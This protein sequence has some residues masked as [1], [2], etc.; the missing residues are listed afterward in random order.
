MTASYVSLFILLILLATLLI[1]P[2]SAAIW[3]EQYM[4]RLKHAELVNRREVMQDLLLENCPEDVS[5]LFS[6][7]DPFYPITL[8]TDSLRNENTLKDELPFYVVEEDEIHFPAFPWAANWYLDLKKDK[9]V[10]GVEILEANPERTVFKYR[11]E[12]LK[13]REAAG[14]RFKVTH[15]HHCGACSSLKD[16]Y[17]YKAFP[18]LT[19]PA[20]S[21]AYMFPIELQLECMLK[22]GFSEPCAEAWAYNA[23]ST[24][25]RCSSICIKN[26]F[27]DSV[28]EKRSLEE[29]T[30]NEDLE[31]AEKSTLDDCLLCDEYV[32]GPGFKYSA[33]R[34]RRSSGLNSSIERRPGEV[35]AH[36]NHNYFNDSI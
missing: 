28:A 25:N 20:K 3:D 13:N 22:I 4:E 11:L 21:C 36:T 23:R 18:D 27:K 30:A 34:T 35:Y 32:S 15:A 17:I 19:R 8:I 2:G 26:R 14:T 16:L 1:V 5:C 9:T 24:R 31:L 10:C 12:T 7:K 33:G 29:D 6:T